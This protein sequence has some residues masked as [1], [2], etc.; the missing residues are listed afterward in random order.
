M[1]YNLTLPNSAANRVCNGA[2]NI[3][4]LGNKILMPSFIFPSSDGGSVLL[5]LLH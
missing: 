4:N 1:I 2:A 3:K 5:P